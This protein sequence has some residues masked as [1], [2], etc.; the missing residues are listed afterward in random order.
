MAKFY[1][2]GSGSYGCLHDSQQGPFETIER[3]AQ[4]AVDTF[5]DALSERQQAALR[6][7]LR[8]HL[9]S[10]LPRKAGADYVEIFEVDADWTC[11]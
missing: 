3:A 6:L 1:A 10:D 9:Y 7:A 5:A 2:H 4:S 8:Q 11:D